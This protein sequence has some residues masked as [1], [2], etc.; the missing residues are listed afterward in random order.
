MTMMFRRLYTF[1]LVLTLLIPA[2]PAHAVDPSEA[3]CKVRITAELTQVN[4]DYRSRLFGSVANGAGWFTVKTGGY[5][6]A[7][8]VGI[9]EHRGRLTSEFVNPLV[10]SYR[11]YRCRSLLVCQ[12]LRLSL[13]ATS[14]APETV[15]LPGCADALM[16]PYQECSAERNSLQEVRGLLTYCS[17]TV[18]A[19]LLFERNVLKLA[20]AYDAGYRADVLQFPGMVDWMMKDMATRNFLPLRAMVNLL[21]KLHQ[22]PC[23]TGQCD[24]PNNDD[25]T[26]TN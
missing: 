12:N 19:S 16:S 10:E 25:L 1:A 9:F 7:Q 5:T 14:N 17:D 26:I 4:D 11:A 2:V 3:T 18:H 13:H 15:F 24:M 8:R 22:I 21:G 23:F 6:D 20:A